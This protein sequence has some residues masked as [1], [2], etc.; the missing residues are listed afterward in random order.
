M[1]VRI[2]IVIIIFDNQ[3][4]RRE[5]SSPFT[6]GVFYVLHLLLLGHSMR[7]S[8]AHECAYNIKLLGCLREGV[9]SS[10]PRI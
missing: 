6:D 7:P 5:L 10:L 2:L 9:Q 3:A 4:F 1:H 8:R